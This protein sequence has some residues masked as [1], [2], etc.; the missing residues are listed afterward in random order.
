MALA[1]GQIPAQSE[2]FPSEQKHFR[3]SP[4]KCKLPIAACAPLLAFPSVI[5]TEH[6]PC[7]VPGE[8]TGVPATQVAPDSALTGS[9]AA[10]AA[11]AVPVVLA[12]RLAVVADS[13]VDQQSATLASPATVHDQ[14]QLL[15]SDY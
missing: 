5:L 13:R 8:Q 6:V 9:V 3:P 7:T 10:P 11:F 12:A 4:S 2:V 1:A 14:R 15:I